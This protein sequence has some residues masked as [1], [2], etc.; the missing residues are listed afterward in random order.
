MTHVILGIDTS[1]YTTSVALIS[2][3]TGLCINQKQKL[4]QTEQGERGL[5]QST[6]LFFHIQ[7]LPGLI[8]ELFDE[9]PAVTL[10][11]VC[12]STTPRPVEGSYMPVFEAAQSVGRSIAAAC[13]VPFYST[14]HQENHIAAALDK[15]ELSS[16]F[17]AL[18]LS[19]GTTELLKV[20]AHPKGYSIDILSATLDISF[21]QLIDR[22]G[23]KLG[24]AFPAGSALEQA[25]QNE[26]P[27]PL[28]PPVKLYR[29]AVSLSG[30]EKQFLDLCENHSPQEIAPALFQYTAALLE[31]WILTHLSDFPC[32]NVLLAGGVA[33]NRIVKKILENAKSLQPVRLHF[34]P[35]ALCRDN[36]VGTAKIGLWQHQLHKG[37]IPCRKP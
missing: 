12:A 11:A 23:V 9:T 31:K 13:K 1:C 29:N 2:V 6:A 37:D 22:I 21:G 8:E 4:L 33:S 36:A 25:V 5:R 34:A 15:T 14:T 18:H 32:Q 28:C 24:F 27:S 30:A 3:E 7:N 20:C 26:E 19:G 17:M 16:P 10:A 35:P